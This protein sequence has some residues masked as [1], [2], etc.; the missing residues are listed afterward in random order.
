MQ[1]RME[2]TK[3]QIHSRQPPVMIPTTRGFAVAREINQGARLLT[4]KSGP[5]PCK[6]SV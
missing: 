5:Y 6:K 1:S 2:I 4:S 3:T